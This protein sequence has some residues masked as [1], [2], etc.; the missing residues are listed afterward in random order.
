MVKISNTVGIS[1]TSKRGFAKI[2]VNVWRSSSRD[3]LNLWG[4]AVMS[5]MITHPEMY[6]LESKTIAA[7]VTGTGTK[8]K[9][10]KLVGTADYIGHIDLPL[11]AS[12]S[13]STPI[14]VT[15]T[16]EKSF[17]PGDMLILV[18]CIEQLVLPSGSETNQIIYLVSTTISGTSAG[19]LVA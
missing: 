1:M 11:L 4:M 12:E 8:N 16:M 3:V 6:T 19:M 2:G 10:Q 15:S 7:E 17:F 9:D 14:S 18:P 13:Q 5:E